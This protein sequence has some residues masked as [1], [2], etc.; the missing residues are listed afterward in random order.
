MHQASDQ[1]LAGKRILV[2]RPAEQAAKLAALISQAGGEAVVFP[3][4]EIV[5]PTNTQALAALVNTLHQFDFAIFI[6]P[7]AVSRAFLHIT[8]W[9]PELHAA[10]I[11][12]GSAKALRQAG[13]QQ[14]IAPAQGNDSEALLAL[15]EM[16]Q[17]SGKRILIFRGEDGR[18]LLAN[19]LRQRGAQVEYAE[20][21]RRAKPQ[22]DIA[23]LLQQHF[24]AVVVTSREGLQNLHDML[25]AGWSILQSLPFFVP[26]PRIASAA[27]LLEIQQAIVTTGGDA[28]C[29]V[30]M[31][32]H[33]HASAQRG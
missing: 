13:I 14:V 6:S 18:E 20:C 16:Q 12:S 30:A 32:Q 27:N 2:T 21:Y 22:A 31:A 7:T 24:D 8:D 1:A 3:A 4:I 15:P 17:V 5:E 33:F 11:G 26:H 19:T 9:P 29:V 23:P 25:G 28:G 10:A